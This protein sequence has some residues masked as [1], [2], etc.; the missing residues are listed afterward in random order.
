MSRTRVP[1]AAV[2]PGVSAGRRSAAPPRVLLGDEVGVRRA[3]G[4]P[5]LVS[6]PDRWLSGEDELELTKIFSPRL[7]KS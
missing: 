5:G 4:L 6:G 1:A 3:G 7:S 2:A